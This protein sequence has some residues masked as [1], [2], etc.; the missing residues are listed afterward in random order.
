M[1]SLPLQ[2]RFNDVDQMGHVNNAVIMEFFDL[3]KEDFFRQHG[4]AP[5]SGD[6]TVM[7]V[8]YEVDFQ[9]QIHF[10]DNISVRTSV[11]RFG[12]RSF[13]L[14]QEIVE[15]HTERLCAACRTVMSGYSRLTHTSAI[16]PDDLRQRLSENADASP[17]T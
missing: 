14:R 6:F 11:E 17:A 12:N 2:I 4:L 1:H 10:H 3:G 7:I 16:I 9:S 13:T 5:E 15:D 8:H